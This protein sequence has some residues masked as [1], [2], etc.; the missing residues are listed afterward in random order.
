M[1]ILK[2]QNVQPDFAAFKDCI[3]RKGTPERVHFFEFYLDSSI[4]EELAKRF[5]LYRGFDDKHPFSFYQKE[6][7][8]QEILGYDM[9]GYSIFPHFPA[10][11]NNRKNIATVSEDMVAGGPVKTWED[12]EQY[13]WPKVSDMDM[14]SLDWLE[15]ELPD[16]MKCYAI[17]PIGLYKRLL[18]YEDMLYMMYDNLPLMKSVMAKVIEIFLDY[19]RLVGQ[20]SCVGTVLGSDD[21]G[22]KTQ[23]FFPPDFI[24]DNILP[25][26][27]ALAQVA[28]DNGKLYFLHACGNLSEIMDDLINNVKIDA[29]HSFEDAIMPVTEMKK[30]YGNRIALLGGLDIDFLCRSDETTLRKKVREILDICIKGGGYCLGSGNSIAKYVPLSNYLIMLDEG[31]KFML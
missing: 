13:P 8:L 15:K 18:G 25:M 26:H 27:R 20:Y 29:K 19:A 4:K 7:V 24:R 23:T 28:H 3:Q 9:V 12:F 11:I 10:E 21:M 5:E 16:N 6:I 30:I 22:F 31:R 2:L 1:D 17:A 14:S